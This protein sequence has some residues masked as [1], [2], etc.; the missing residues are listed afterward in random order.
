[1]KK[2]N[3]QIWWAMQYPV[4]IIA[5]NSRLFHA[6]RVKYARVV[7]AWLDGRTTPLPWVKATPPQGKAETE[8]EIG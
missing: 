5:P 4:W 7:C 3:A 6:V 2:I 8:K 1:M